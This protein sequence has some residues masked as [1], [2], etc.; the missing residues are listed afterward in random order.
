MLHR[1]ST[2]ALSWDP[3][4]SHW[5]HEHATRHQTAPTN[6]HAHAYAAQ[7]QA[8]GNLKLIP[9]KTA[10]CIITRR[11]SLVWLHLLSRED[12]S[13]PTLTFELMRWEKAS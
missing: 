8:I 13:F 10:W 11:G 6:A 5:E 4:G 12:S 9:G 3:S 7:N 2:G 1:R